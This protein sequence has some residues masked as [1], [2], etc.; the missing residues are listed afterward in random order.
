MHDQWKLVEEQFRPATN[1]AWEGLLTQGNGYMHVRASLAEHLPEAPQNVDYT[2]M[3][4]NVTAEEFPETKAKWGTYVPGVFGPHPLLGS[5]MINLP[6]FLDLVPTVGAD[7]LSME[8]AEGQV[9]GGRELDLRTATLRRNLDWETREGTRVK[10]L[11]ERFV[12]ASRPHLC[13]QRMQIEA[14]RA[15]DLIVRAGIDADVRTNG[16]DHFESV[17]LSSHGPT[18]ILCE[19]ATDGGDDVQILSVMRGGEEEWSRGRTGERQMRRSTRMSI[20]AGQRITI[21]KRTALT[22][23]R[24]PDHAPP[25]EF[26]AEGR[27]LTWERLHEEHCAVWRD[28]WEKSDVVVEGDPRSQLAL[29]A[30][31]YHL[32]R[33]HPG[34]DSRVSIDAKGYAGEAYWGRYFWDTD[35]YLLPF[36]LYTRPEAA[37]TLVEFRRRTLD[38]ARQN[39]ERYG[40]VG[41]RYA[42][43]S[44]HRGLE[45][46]PSWQY[47]DHQVHVTA[48]VIY[49]MAHYSRAADPEYLLGPGADVLRETARYWMERIDRRPDDD[50]PSILGVMGPDEYSPITQNNSYTNRQVALVLRRAAELEDSAGVDQTERR[51]FAETADGLPVLR[52]TQE[53]RPD[54]V[55]QCE[56]FELLA[57]PPFDLWEDRSRPC[58]AQVSQERIYRSRCLKQPD[59]LLLMMLYPNEFTTEEMQRAWDYYVPLTTHDSSLSPGVHAIMACR[60]GRTQE[61]WEFW[62]RSA[63]LDLDVEHGAVAEGIHIAAAA[64]N[65]QVAVLGFAGLATVMESDVLTLRPN[66]PETWSKLEFPLVWKGTPIQVTITREEVVLENRGEAPIDARVAGMPVSVGAGSRKRIQL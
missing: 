20:R 1:R 63:G 62:R 61:A 36:Y 8:A 65:W 47:R 54:L 5:E 2:R 15:T 29:R 56:E 48:D 44:D 34:S 25:S 30:S 49:G 18:G 11:Y 6:F 50:H 41:A 35:I 53:G 26:L 17:E 64:N 19:L 59:V 4:A 60:L 16:Y 51:A 23:S 24:D 45:C 38:G 39:A 55:M 40:Y 13:L 27:D 52:K 3:P 43:E 66:L 42:W 22:T 10:V 57:A 7:F 28:H 37:R 46:C 12:S 21:E 31:I 32:L 9:A 58:A 33:A 14:D